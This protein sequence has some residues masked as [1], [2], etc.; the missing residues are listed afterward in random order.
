MLSLVILWTSV[1]SCTAL[2]A[3]GVAAD[4][5]NPKAKAGFDVDAQVGKTNT[6]NDSLLQHSTGDHIDVEELGTL[7]KSIKNTYDDIAEMHTTHNSLP[8][9]AVVLMCLGWAFL[10]VTPKEIWDRW[11]SFT[12]NTQT[13]E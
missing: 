7:D 13:K 8:I 11:T 2:D 1:N 10:F 6:I 9:W 4:V 12:D 3:V 5:V